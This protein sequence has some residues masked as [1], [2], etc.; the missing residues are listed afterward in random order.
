MDA[1]PLTPAST[2]R[3]RAK[4]QRRADLLKEASRLFAIR[5]YAGVSLEDL[6]AACGISG[7]AVYRH[8][9]GKSAV[10]IALLVG[11]SRDLLKGG[12]EVRANGGSAE[13]ILGKLIEFHTDFTLTRPEMIQVQERS[14]DALPEAELHLVRKLQREY[15]ALWTEQL[16]LIH[17]QESATVIRFRAHAAFGLLNSPAHSAHNPRTS[18]KGLRKLL[19]QMATAALSTPVG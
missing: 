12:K 9:S 11:M 17:P 10:L 16:H 1:M 8:F 19:N 5:G 13:E 6:G 7:P 14:L 15:I 2:D 4:A 3:D 18:K